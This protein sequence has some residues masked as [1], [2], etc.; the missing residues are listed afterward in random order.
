MADDVLLNK[1]AA[2][3]R[4]IGRVR[5][6]HA[7]DDRNLLGNQTRQDAI[8]LN[9]QRA[10]RR[11]FLQALATAASFRPVVAQAG[12]PPVGTSTA[13]RWHRGMTAPKGRRVASR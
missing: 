2:I 8:I 10:F 12:D 7:G 9:L 13:V 3:E 4:A 5:E 11:L 6:E 1:A